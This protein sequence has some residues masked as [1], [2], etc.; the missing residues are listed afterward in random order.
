MRIRPPGQQ[1]NRNKYI[2]LVFNILYKHQAENGQRAITDAGCPESDTSPQASHFG[3]PNTATSAYSKTRKNMEDT[4]LTTC[5]LHAKKQYPV[6]AGASAYAIAGFF[7]TPRQPAHRPSAT[8][9]RRLLRQDLQCD[10]AARAYVP[11]LF[12][13]M[14]C[15]WIFSPKNRYI[16]I[17]IQ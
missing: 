13:G 3:H 10:F 14:Q 6:I 8:A 9:C 7:A 1:T 15:I 17:V 11:Q 4:R 12:Y 5:I 16:R 2:P